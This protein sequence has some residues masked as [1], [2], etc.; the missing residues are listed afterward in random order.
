MI[1]F[2]EFINEEHKVL[3]KDADDRDYSG[4][5]DVIKKD[6]KK[7]LDEI[8]NPTN[9]IMYRGL[10]KDKNHG[11]I[12]VKDAR[13][14]RRPLNTDDKLSDKIDEWFKQE[15][16]IRFRSQAVFAVG[17][18]IVAKQYGDI[19]IMFPIGDY[20]YIWSPNYSDLTEDVSRYFEMHNREYPDEYDYFFK[21]GTSSIKPE[22]LNDFMEDANFKFNTGLVDALTRHRWNEIMIRCKKYYLVYANQTNGAQ[23]YFLTLLKAAL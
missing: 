12:S 5:F 10:D 1:T 3:Y 11:F 21:T 17:H 14:D 9:V 22:H 2:K 15:Y 16:G 20:D 18:R 8:K 4:F 6:C 13:T 19:Y 23:D 7:Y